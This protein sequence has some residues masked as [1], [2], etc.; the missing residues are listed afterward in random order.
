MEV[1]SVN[2]KG[3]NYENKIILQGMSTNLLAL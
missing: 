3:R 1:S 2:D